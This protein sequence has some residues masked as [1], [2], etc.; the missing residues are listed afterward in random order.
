[1]KR[2]LKELLDER[3]VKYYEAEALALEAD[4]RSL[5]AEERTS[6]TTLTSEV[7]ELDSQIATARA[8]EAFAAGRAASVGSGAEG[9]RD[10]SKGD[11][12]DLAGFNL[13]R[14]LLARI[15]QRSL[16]GVEAEMQVE[17][18]KRALADGIE[19]S[20][21]GIVVLENV[22][23]KRG[24]TVTLQTNNPGDQG[25]VLVEKKVQGV[26]EV[27]QA[28]TFLDKVGARFMTGLT[29]NLSFPV[30]ET[31][32]VIQE[33]TEIEQMTDS[34]ILFSA[35]DM[36][37]ARR[38]TTIPVSK[39]LLKQTSFDMQN[40]VITAIAE[41][42]AQKMN[43]EAISNLLTIITSG[44]GNLL[45]LG[46][47]G[48][49]PTYNDIV[50]LEGLVDQYN[51]N[52]GEAK[53]LTNSKVRAKLKT[54]QKFTGTNGE[55]VYSDADVL[56]GYKAI[57]SNV[58]PSNLTKGTATGIASAIIFGNFSDFFVGTWGGTEYIVDPY[59]AKRKAQVEITA[60]AFWAMKAARV[61]SFAGIK[62]ALT[63]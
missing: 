45:A 4:K 48:A 28:N 62:D 10:T 32:P 61:K 16:D 30:Q 57:I 50:A 6:F 59:S 44:N 41:A 58:V 38:G 34:E 25:G 27:L 19:L 13:N 20:G 49:V 43:A 12:R 24:Q 5:N 2:T 29:G 47:N 17:A 31:M 11:Q 8:L 14:A 40:F 15:E 53:Y 54:T 7:A 39:Q 33:L 60:N 37:P 26:L 55:A 9:N 22:P 36:I 35:F 63:A 52:R 3:S 21:N 1:M 42:L 46:T 51:H 18:E 56:N 23:Q